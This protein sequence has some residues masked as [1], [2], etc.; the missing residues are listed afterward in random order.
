MQTRF[1]P[2]TET[3]KVLAMTEPMNTQFAVGQLLGMIPFL[4]YERQRSELG[5]RLFIEANLSFRR[6]V[7]ALLRSDLAEAKRLFDLAVQPQGIPLDKIGAPDSV[8]LTVLLP[9][10]RELLKKYAK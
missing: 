3:E 10:Y 5:N 2:L 4:E 8:E 7:M 6:G 1:T 9:K